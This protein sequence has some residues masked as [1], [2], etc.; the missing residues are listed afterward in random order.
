MLKKFLPRRDFFFDFFE[1]HAF[2]A[3]QAAQELVRFNAS[4]QS[5]ADI[6]AKIHQFEH[7]GDKITHECVER[8]HKTFI[9]PIDRM[10]IHRLITTLDNV[11][12]EIEDIA[13]LMVVY[14]LDRFKKDAAHL[15]EILVSSTKEMSLAIGELRN[16]KISGVVQAHFFN[17]NHLENEADVIYNQSLGRL[18]EQESDVKTLIKWKEVY[19][20]LEQAIDGCEDVSNIL[21]GIILEN[22]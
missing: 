1:K 6:F 4:G 9:T 12:D 22:E 10:D 19:E 16:M 13:K 3:F 20:H 18:F 14:K 8:L 11:V 2:L 17:I 7:E 5:P 15:A 21:E